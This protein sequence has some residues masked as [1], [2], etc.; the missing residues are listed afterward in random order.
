MN[1][2][3]VLRRGTQRACII[4][5]HSHS[6]VNLVWKLGVVDSGEKFRFFSGNFTQIIDFSGQNSEKIRFCQ[7]IILQKFPFFKTNFQRISIFSGNL[8]KID[9]KNFNF[10]GNLPKN[11]DFVQK[12]RYFTGNFTKKID[13]SRQISEK[14]RFSQVVSLKISISQGKFPKNFDF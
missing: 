10:L 14:F 4:L 11:F 7:V 5:A 9:F 3:T 6:G 2:Q 1:T 12:F 8:K 13:F